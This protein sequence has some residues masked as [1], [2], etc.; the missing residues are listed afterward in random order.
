MPQGG[1]GLPPCDRGA[2]AIACSHFGLD[3]IKAPHLVPFVY[4]VGA[5]NIMARRAN[6]VIC[7]VSFISICASYLSAAAGIFFAY[8]TEALNPG[9]SKCRE[10]RDAFA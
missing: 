7:S 9:R 3:I 2:Y 5:L 4:F 8:A 10:N 1:G 6:S